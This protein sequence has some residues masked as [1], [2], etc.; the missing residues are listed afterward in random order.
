ME[1]IEL[2]FSGLSRCYKEWQ[3]DISGMLFCL[4]VAHFS[5]SIREWHRSAWLLF[6]VC[7]FLPGKQC[8]CLSMHDQIANINPYVDNLYGYSLHFTYMSRGVNQGCGVMCKPDSPP[9]QAEHST[10]NNPQSNTGTQDW[11]DLHKKQQGEREW[12]WQKA[13]LSKTFESPLSIKTPTEG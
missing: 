13:A 8:V 6:V 9:P 2:W 12:E 4:M 7:M 5:C 10:H 11:I 1:H 3:E